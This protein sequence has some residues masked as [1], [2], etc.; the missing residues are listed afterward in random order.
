MSGGYLLHGERTIHRAKVAA[1][2]RASAQCTRGLEFDPCQN[3]EPNK[4]TTSMI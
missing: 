3:T 2:G 1:Q 4:N